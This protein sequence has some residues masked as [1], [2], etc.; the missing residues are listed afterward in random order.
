LFLAATKPLFEL[1]NG[2]LGEWGRQSADLH[3]FRI[4]R[5]PSRE[6][7]DVSSGDSHLSAWTIL[8]AH[9]ETGRVYITRYRGQGRCEE[10]SALASA[11]RAIAQP[12]LLLSTTTGTARSFGSNTRSQEQ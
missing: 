2:E 9:E 1:R 7:P 5:V 3:G 10:P 12:S 11:V 6:A 4:I 8:V